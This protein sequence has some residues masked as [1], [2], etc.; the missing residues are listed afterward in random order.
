MGTTERWVRL[1][2]IFHAA[3]EYPEAERASFI[4]RECGDDVA[5]RREVEG[6]FA[7]PQLDSIGIMRQFQR[8]LEIVNPEEPAEPEEDDA[9]RVGMTFDHYRIESL[10]GRGGMGWVYRAWDE[11]LARSVAIKFLSL[12]LVQDSRQVRHF[13]EEARKASRTNHPGIVTIYDAGEV[14]NRHFIVMEYIDGRN[15]RELIRV[16][17]VGA[18]NLARS[19]SIAVQIAEALQAAHQ[20]QV[21]HRDIKPENVMVTNDGRVKV[22]DFGL[23]VRQEVTE[24]EPLPRERPEPGESAESAAFGTPEYLAPEQLNKSQ[25]DERTDIYSFGIL[26]HELVTGKRPEQKT[27]ESTVTQSRPESYPARIRQIIE[28][29]LAPAPEN[30]YASAAPLR[31]DLARAQDRLQRESSSW[32]RRLKQVAAAI[33]AIFILVVL[34]YQIYQRMTRF[35]FR[36]SQTSQIKIQ[37]PF[38]LA[39]ISP[40]GRYLVY[41]SHEQS[42]FNIWVRDMQTSKEKMLN[43]PSRSGY[44]WPTITP[45][46]QFIYISSIRAMEGEKPGNQLLRINL[47]SGAAEELLEGVDSPV[48][49]SP[50]GSALAYVTEEKGN[51]KSRSILIVAD[52]NGQQRREISVRTTPEFYTLDGPVWSPDGRT[53][54]VTAGTANSPLYYNVVGVDV[55]SGRERPLTSRQWGHVLGLEWM[56]DSVGLILSGKIRG[57]VPNH[58]LH[59]LDTLTGKDKQFSFDDYDYF[60]NPGL[61][62]IAR[63][64]GRTGLGLVTIRRQIHTSFCFNTPARPKEFASYSTGVL[65]DGYEGIGLTPDGKILYSSRIDDDENIWMTDLN[66]NKWKLT[67]NRESNRDPVVSPDGRVIVFSSSL[68]GN[69]RIYRVN[70]DGSN[71][72][73]LTQ[74]RLDKEPE[75][76]P[77]GKWV[78]YSTE[79]SQKRTIWR[80]PLAGGEAKQLTKLATESPV[81][82]PDGDWIACLYNEDRVAGK[83]AIFPA[84]GGEPVR[85]LIL[86]RPNYPR[87]NYFRWSPDGE[88]LDY[89]SLQDNAANIW[90]QPLN[91]AAPFKLTDFTGQTIS[92]FEWSA[93]GQRLYCVR[94]DITFELI[95]K[96]Q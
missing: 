32:Y 13:I 20:A 2:E 41:I 63:S 69:P 9:I 34:G 29:C 58:H 24:V 44:L 42:I 78:V 93:D 56:P 92:D 87:Y 67:H 47:Q 91:G 82:S 39:T 84:E 65:Q 28:K 30:R 88:A 51:K 27:T 36:D 72:V 22:V 18:A 1:Q 53:I 75:I 45:D 3:A 90:R 31:V 19:L 10:I 17:E 40:N 11:R 85:F 64:D 59:Y 21:I 50:D 14:E 80:V 33:P 60:G 89:I 79:N 6:L 55:Q 57:T 35:P 83:V 15:L 43:H 52:R 12:R 95:R 7:Q 4:E 49:F 76:T 77:D 62:R 23:A 66:G 70:I 37:K 16:G 54:A 86:P 71:Q 8:H 38:E 26:L 81:I 68:S 74:G 5:L 94:N 73:E 25:V 48:S 46:S 61:A 96:E